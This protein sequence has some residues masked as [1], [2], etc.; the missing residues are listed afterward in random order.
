MTQL[1]QETRLLRDDLNSGG[2]KVDAFLVPGPSSGIPEKRKGKNK[3]LNTT[4][5]NLSGDKT[6]VK[7]FG[8]RVAHEDDNINRS[9][10]KSAGRSELSLV[11]V[12]TKPVNIYGNTLTKTINDENRILKRSDIKNMSEEE[13]FD[14]FIEV[15][16]KKEIEWSVPRNRKSIRKKKRLKSTPNKDSTQSDTNPEYDLSNDNYVNSK[17]NAD[18]GV[19]RK[20]NVSNIKSKPIGNFKDKV[21]NLKRKVPRT[22][23]I[24]IL[25]ESADI[26]YS[27]IL[28][29]AREN[30]S[31]SELNICDTKIKRSITGG[32]LIEI[33]GEE[34]DL[35]A[36]MLLSRL[37]H[38]FKDTNGVKIRKPIKNSQLKL[39]GLDDSVSTSEICSILADIGKCSTDSISCSP[40]RFVRGGLGVAYVRCPI[41]AA[42]GILEATRIN[43]GWTTVRVEPMDPKPLQCFRCLAVGHTFQRCPESK[44]RRN[45]CYRC[46]EFTHRAS[47]CRNRIKCPACVD[48]GL[49][50]DHLA[51]TLA[52]KP[53]PP[54]KTLIF[55][56]NKD[57]DCT[58]LNT[59]PVIHTEER[60][61][62][63]TVESSA[64][65]METDNLNG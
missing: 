16:N 14:N 50:D 15:D 33:P 26:T 38:L 12:G 36:D 10:K 49:K 51:G 24:S 61:S 9:C 55:N 31:L 48:R 5:L 27:E 44:D 21:A 40:V 30:I 11:N 23:A 41:A 46:G 6:Y 3:K 28:R 54:R 22:S 60:R 42:V 35:K 57:N 52:C 18:Y 17:R 20:N 64:C 8:S 37:R 29:M 53:I 2:S 58:H 45:C 7:A 63:V 59:L 4:N 62:L 43:I 34:S 19:A 25:S 39:M 1:I 32:I 65:E 56:V 13:I 47:E